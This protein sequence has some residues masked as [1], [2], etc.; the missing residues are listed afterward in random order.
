[1]KLNSNKFEFIILGKSTEQYIMVNINNI[2]IRKS[3]SVV[4]LGPPIDNR[5]Y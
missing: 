2:K 1:M 4:L 3:S 5:S